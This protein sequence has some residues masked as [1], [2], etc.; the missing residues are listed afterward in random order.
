ME[1]L[2]IDYQT[3][4]GKGWGKYIVADYRWTK[5]GKKEYYDKLVLNQKRLNY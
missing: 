2:D 4:T 1:F 5:K 3:N